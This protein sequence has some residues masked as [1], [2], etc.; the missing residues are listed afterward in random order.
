[1]QLEWC[2]PKY[3]TGML[4]RDVLGAVAT[5]EGRVPFPLRMVLG[6]VACMAPAASVA[7]TAMTAMVRARVVVAVVAMMRRWPKVDCK[8][9]TA[10]QY[11]TVHGSVLN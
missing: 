4:A 2:P 9:S 11:Q 1:M 5:P 8:S 7:R 6:M 10:R 3:A